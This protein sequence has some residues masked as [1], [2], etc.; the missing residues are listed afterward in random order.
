MKWLHFIG[1][2]LA[3]DEVPPPARICHPSCLLE[4]QLVICDPHQYSTIVEGNCADHV[5]LAELPRLIWIVFSLLLNRLQI[6][7]GILSDIL[8]VVDSD[9]LWFAHSQTPKVMV[10]CLRSFWV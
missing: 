4:D 5:L 7:G 1:L 2:G 6:G 9:C 3:C 10:S 8:N